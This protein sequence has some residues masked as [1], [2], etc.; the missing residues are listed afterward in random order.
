VLLVLLFLQIKVG[1]ITDK[2]YIPNG[3][4]KEQYEKIRAAE[5]AKKEANYKRNVA[6][7][8]KFEDFT[9][10]YKARGTDISDNWIKSVTRGHRMV[11]TKYDFS[12]KDKSADKTPEQFLKK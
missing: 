8:G 4:T 7:A 1:K 11:K 6:K 12:G 10:W 2:S 9:E 5:V 3:L